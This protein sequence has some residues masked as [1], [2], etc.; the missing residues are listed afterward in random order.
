MSS[1]RRQLLPFE[2][3]WRTGRLRVWTMLIGLNFAVFITQ[4][5]MDL[6]AQPGLVN[7]WL[8]LNPHAI[9][10][11]QFWQFFSY[12]FLHG[13]LPGSGWSW[14]VSRSTHLLLN[15]FFLAY[16]GRELEVILGPSHLLGI[17]LGGG[18]TGGLLQFLLSWNTSLPLVGASAGVCAVLF[19][20]TTVLPEMEM[21]ML[22]FFMLP[23]HLRAKYFGAGVL[24]MLIGLALLPL[25]T[26]VALWA[27]V[28]G[29]VFGWAYARKLGYG[30]A[31]RL[32][33]YLAQRRLRAERL[34]RMDPHQFIS[35]EVDPILEK[36]SRQGMH[37]LTRRERRLLE[38]GREKIAEEK[39]P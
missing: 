33:I 22:F 19:A 32:Q 15:L 13:F 10:D 29:A 6:F 34:D 11:G 36:I 38:K 26:N 1:P 18:V 14:L 35:E 31:S 8:G 21:S 3:S 30:N 2:R 37:S 4:T 7:S 23:L 24:L 5:G 25:P 28:G 20:F 39:R 16:A 27:C 9:R 12:L 17:Y